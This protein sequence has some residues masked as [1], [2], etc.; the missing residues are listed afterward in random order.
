MTACT[1]RGSGSAGDPQRTSEPEVR[2]VAATWAS[3]AVNALTRAQIGGEL[4]VSP[5]TERGIVA[6][7]RGWTCWPEFRTRK[8]VLRG[9]VRRYRRLVAAL[10]G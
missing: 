2:L 9:G 5:S 3:H 1:P 8:D 4:S 10:A 7:R 6:C